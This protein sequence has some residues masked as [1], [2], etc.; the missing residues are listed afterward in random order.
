MKPYSLVMLMYFWLPVVIIGMGIIVVKQRVD[1]HLEW[2]AV[3]ARGVGPIH[4][5][6]TKETLE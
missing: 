4:C 2:C 6:I 1:Q 3:H 5:L